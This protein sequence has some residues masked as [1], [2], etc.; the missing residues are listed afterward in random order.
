MP[1]TSE[2]DLIAEARAILGTDEEILGAGYF[3]LANLRE[4]QVIG[5]T[6][7]ALA[8]TA[9]ADD[10]TPGI[11]TLAGSM[12]AVKASAEEQGV[13]VKLLVAVTPD[14]IHVLNQDTGGRLRAEVASF[15]RDHVTIHIAKVGL[16]RILTLTDPATGAAI[17]LHGAVSWLA[18][19]ST[20]DKVVLQLLQPDAD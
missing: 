14:T 6:A 17:E 7:G 10:L 3:G 11:G 15:R 2:A 18:A 13:T 12:L 16:S 4:A 19:Q 9:A 1:G 8:T 5:G 20:G